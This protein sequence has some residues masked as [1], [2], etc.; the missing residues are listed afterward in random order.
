M[1]KKSVP[2]MLVLPI[3]Q[4]DMQNPLIR[5]PK[6]LI[7]RVSYV[8]GLAGI[9]SVRTLVIKITKH[10]LMVNFFPMNLNPINIGNALRERFTT[11]YGILKWRKVSQTPCISRVIPAKPAGKSPPALTKVLIF[12]AKMTDA[13]NPRPNRFISFI[14]YLLYTIMIYA[15]YSVSIA[16]IQRKRN[17]NAVT[18]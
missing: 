11:E 9:I 2:P 8:M 18:T 14:D 15:I 17:L 5:P 7:S 12:M 10:E 6:M 13:I 1:A 4:S 3:R 16:D